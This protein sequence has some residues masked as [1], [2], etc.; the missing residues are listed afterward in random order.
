MPEFLGIMLPN[1]T[2][3]PWNYGPSYDEIKNAKNMKILNINHAI[4]CFF[5]YIVL[6][7]EKVTNWIQI[8]ILTEEGGIVKTLLQDWIPIVSLWTWR[9]K[10]NPRSSLILPAG[11]DGWKKKGRKS[12]YSVC[13]AYYRKIITLVCILKENQYLLYSFKV[14]EAFHPN[15]TLL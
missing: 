3:V 5:K 7:W 12:V 9:M 6:L 8:N 13:G 15:L 1:F 11:L 2:T 10:Y 14:T 4:L